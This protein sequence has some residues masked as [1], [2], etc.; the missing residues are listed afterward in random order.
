MTKKQEF[1]KRTY[2]QE[3][4]EAKALWY[5]LWDYK[6]LYKD[7]SPNELLKEDFL[8][9]STSFGRAVDK[10]RENGRWLQGSEG[11]YFFNNP[12]HTDYILLSEGI[13]E[14]VRCYVK[15]NR[16]S[17]HDM[18]HILYETEED[19]SKIESLLEI[20]ERVPFSFR[21]IEKMEAQRELRRAQERMA[22]FEK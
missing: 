7:K 1:K 13:I 19:L 11:N 8:L 15:E 20:K 17:P 21:A 9:D 12:T 14:V 6:Y 4:T 5:A 3:G 18:L 10:G 2:H 22:K 16:V